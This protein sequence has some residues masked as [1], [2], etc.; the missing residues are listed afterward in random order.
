[1]QRPCHWNTEQLRAQDG[2]SWRR[3]LGQC[4][5][6]SLMIFVFIPRTMKNDGSVYDKV[7]REYSR[8]PESKPFVVRTRGL[9][10]IRHN[11]R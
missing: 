4:P 1:M 2:G 3:T 10:L 8:E 11:L 5:G 7:F 9:Y 6:A